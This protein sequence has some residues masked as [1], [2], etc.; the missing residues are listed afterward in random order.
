MDC[1]VVPKL[2]LP[3]KIFFK[4]F[5]FLICREANW[6]DRT[7]AFYGRCGKVRELA[8]LSNALPWYQI[9]AFSRRSSHPST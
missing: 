3:T 8:R 5:F 7:A 4:L 6:Q 1:S 9:H 2:R